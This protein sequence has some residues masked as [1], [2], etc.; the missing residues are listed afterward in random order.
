M[1]QPKHT[2]VVFAFLMSCCMAALVSAIVTAVNTGLDHGFVSR[3]LS[4][5]LVA[6]PVAFVSLLLLKEVVLKWAARLTGASKQ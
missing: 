5:Y 2:P 1:L 6:W 3:W 4:S